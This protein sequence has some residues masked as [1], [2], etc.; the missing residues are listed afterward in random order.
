[1]RSLTIKMGQYLAT[2]QR[3]GNFSIVGATVQTRGRRFS[4]WEKTPGNWRVSEGGSDKR[5]RFVVQAA[6]LEQAVAT[7]AAELFGERQPAE[8]VPTIDEVF[9]HWVDSL[10]CSDESIR[11]YQYNI[12]YFVDWIDANVKGL[13]RWVDLRLEHLQGYV[14]FQFGRGKLPK[15]VTHYIEPIR[16]AS[17][18]A[19]ANWPEQ[20]RDF[21]G[22]FRIP[23]HVGGIRYDERAG[24]SFLPFSDVLSLLTWLQENQGERNIIAG[25]A[26]QGLCGLRVREVLRLRWE[27][28]DLTAGTVT[29]QGTVKNPGSC[30]RIPIPDLV[31]GILTEHGQPS[32][33]LLGLYGHEDAYGRAF[34]FLR[35]RWR[36]G[37]L[38]EP[39]G[40]RR[41]LP[42]EANQ[43]AWRGDV[44]ERYLG[45]VLQ[46]I[47]DRHYIGQDEAS[48]Q[49][50]YR[51]QVLSH[52]EAA[53]K[54]WSAKWPRSGTDEKVV[55]LRRV[56]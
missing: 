30:R 27:D 34:R 20:F 4:V 11:D 53:I 23:K 45:H 3:R 43:G 37:C 33:R 1:M 10:T 47:T 9:D 40:L 22:G 49:A 56:L 32:G 8:S 46:S 7:A 5:R 13:T 35:D 50:A 6:D 24:K 41:T 21:A 26:L 31:C 12:L 2:H 55:A 25:V 16:R 54:G 38:I 51:H 15:T 14:A 18:W 48:N 36:P 29:I 28:V 19:A 52:V 44:L 17:K 42:T 39:K